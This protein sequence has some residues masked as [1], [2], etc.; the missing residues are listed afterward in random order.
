M[1]EEYLSNLIVV[2]RS[3]KKVSFDGTKIAIAIKK[4]FDSIDG[5]YNEDDVNKIYNKVIEK[6]IKLN[7]QKIKIED[8]QDLIEEELKANNYADVYKSFAEYREKRNQSREIFFEEKRKHKFLKALEKLGLTTKENSSLINNDKNAVE[9]MEAYGKTVSEEFTTSYLMKKKYSDSHENGDI[10]INKI[11]NYPMGTTESVQMDLEKLFTDGFSAGNCS[12][13]EPQSISSYTMLAVIAI[14]SNQKDQDGETS[15]PAFDY[16]M[17]PGVI[18]TFKK[19]FRETIYSLLEYTDYDK[20]IAING[21]EREIDKLSSI[22]F[23]I[24]DF[25]KFTRNS[26][27]LKRM[28]R[29]CYKKSLEKTNEQTYQAMEG[30]VHDLNSLAPTKI[31]T[32]N[33]GTDTSSEG[34]M[35][36][37]NLLRTIE[38]GIGENKVAISPKVVFK[39]SDDVNFEENSKNYDL[40]KKAV[41]VAIKTDN[42]SFSFIDSSY[43]SAFYKE[44][45]Y[46]TE[47]SYFSD[48]TR[49]I[50]NLIDEDKAVSGGRGVISSTTINLPRIALK[51]VDKISEFW[52]DLDE[53]LNL[54]KDQ[55][56]ERLEIQNNK[57]CENF[58]FLMGESVWLDSEKIKVEDKIK[59]VLK[60][61]VLQIK[62]TG[63][64]ETIYLLTN[65][66]MEESKKSM[67]LAIQ[68]VKTMRETIDEFSKKSGITFVLAGNYDEEID[69]DFLDF[70][71]VIFG[72]VKNITDKEKY[73]N[74]FDISSE[75]INKKI[76][77]ES[78]FFEY[79]NGGHRFEIKIEKAKDK[80]NIEK[81]EDKL[82][83]ILKDLR[84]NDIGFAI[85]Q[86]S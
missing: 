22:D 36:T 38:E 56:L 45:D 16:Y 85:V 62:F 59:R 47:V 9:M 15:I 1:N 17:A 69:K 54:I 26:E 74:S 39:I 71:R 78:Q 18:K 31:T 41:E 25:Y 57:K 24:E 64:E 58:P 23:N 48:G 28:F 86:K 75:N 53:E 63:L 12:M 44:G 83:K 68:I 79:T 66:K 8:I 84:K 3:G 49:V 2:K 21:I 4:G 81:E 70:D 30:F 5:K 35:V 32:I 73:C 61:G 42:I 50:D 14:S 6:I 43:N 55:Q 72:K 20:F 82:L 11:E 80:E 27:E 60:Q 33:L 40:F 76:E 34:R 65:E 67:D 7:V 19:V 46:N 51:N 13:R 37:S 29:I 77:C 52:S 10:F